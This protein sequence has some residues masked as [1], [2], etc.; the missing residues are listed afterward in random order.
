MPDIFWETV[1][2]F[3]SAFLRL[4]NPDRHS[5]RCDREG[6]GDSLCEWEPGGEQRG[7]RMPVGMLTV[8]EQLQWLE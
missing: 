1:R 8:L 4:T 7:E 5:P 2:I 3:N 6:A